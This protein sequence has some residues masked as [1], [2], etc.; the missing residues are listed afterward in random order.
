M[1]CTESEGFW[2]RLTSSEFIR[3]FQSKGPTAQEWLYINLKCLFSCA[4]DMSEI[5]G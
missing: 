2:E 1:R 3:S 5:C 4:K